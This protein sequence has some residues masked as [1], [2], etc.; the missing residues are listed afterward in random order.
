MSFGPYGGMAY[1]GD[2]GDPHR[3][4]H[5]PPVTP[6]EVT[7]WAHQRIGHAVIP[8]KPV[9]QPLPAPG[10]LVAVR[11][12]PWAATIP[13]TVTRVQPCDVISHP[14]WWGGEVDP[15]LWVP[16]TNPDGTAVLDGLGAPA[17][18]PKWDPWPWLDLL[19]IPTDRK[20]PHEY[21]A[22]QLLRCKE[23]R[24]RG[25]AGWLWPGHVLDTPWTP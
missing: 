10:D 14:D 24:V 15:D 6:A 11:V 9:I 25:S 4:P 16:I 1:I 23:A 7:E 3:P 21:R 19:T 2:P 18:R 12:R 5:E 17:Y 22:G 13:A 20:R 8:G